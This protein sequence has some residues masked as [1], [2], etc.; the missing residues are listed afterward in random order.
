MGNFNQNLTTDKDDNKNNLNIEPSPGKGAEA[1]IKINKLNLT[2][3]VKKN[4]QLILGVDVGGVIID[5][6]RKY[7]DIENSMLDPDFLSIPEVADAIDVLSKLNAGKFSG[8]I[9]L[10]SKC[11]REEAEQVMEW[12]GN[13][14]FFRRTGIDITH[15]HFCLNR[16]DKAAICR[17][18]HITHLVDDR[19]EIL[20]SLK[21]LKRY[22]FNPTSVE[23]KLNEGSL[24]GVKTVYSWIE[25]ED[26]LS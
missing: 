9:Y 26:L 14:D 21:G 8:S 4:K 11:S 19:L 24:P 25:L 17:K 2:P 18:Y 22:L 16:E 5:I 23:M 15:V 20:G 7:G 6:D 10:V 3:G 1:S 12:L 13:K